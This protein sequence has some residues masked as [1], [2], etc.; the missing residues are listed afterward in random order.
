MLLRVRRVRGSAGTASSHIHVRDG[1]D[2]S[3]DSPTIGMAANK[4]I[5]QRLQAA[6]IGLDGRGLGHGRMNEIETS[7]NVG[8]LQVC[9]SACKLN[10][11]PSIC[12]FSCA[13]VRYTL[14]PTQQRLRGPPLEASRDCLRSPAT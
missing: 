5:A 9:L 12:P 6:A 2:Y 7:Q 4:C 8:Q 14:P 1:N 13:L 10:C 11:P 3:S